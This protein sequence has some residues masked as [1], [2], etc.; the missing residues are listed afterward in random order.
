MMIKRFIKFLWIEFLYNGHMQ[1][2]GVACIVFGASKIFFEGSVFYPVLATYLLFQLIYIYDRY[3]DLYDDHAT[4][5]TRSE[6]LISYT[7]YIPIVFLFYF[8]LLSIILYYTAHIYGIIFSYCVLVAGL[9]YPVFF[10]NLTKIIFLFKNIYVSTVFSLM[11]IYANIYFN[12]FTESVVFG[13]FLFLYIFLET[14]IMQFNLDCKDISVD[15]MKGLKTL[16]VQ[17]GFHNAL[18]IIYIVVILKALIYF[19]L[20]YFNISDQTPQLIY[21]IIMTTIINLIAAYLIGK[22]ISVG[23]LMSAGKF[24]LWGLIFLVSF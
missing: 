8:S 22:Q 21:I 11:A 7:K 9:L 23:Y 20:L 3:H 2:L 18:K 1:A 5:R 10:K 4:N 13:L 19:A 6:H 17:F 12:I 16:P 15:R 14:M 24:L